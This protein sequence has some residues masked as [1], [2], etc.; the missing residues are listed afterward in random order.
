MQITNEECNKKYLHFLHCLTKVFFF[1]KSYDKN[2]QILKWLSLDMKLFVFTL[3]PGGAIANSWAWN[4]R[5][6]WPGEPGDRGTF[7]PSEKG[8]E[9]GKGAPAHHNRRVPLFL[10]LVTIYTLSPSMHLYANTYT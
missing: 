4:T 7:S 9:R 6:S 3:F 8:R 5:G 10:Y 2:E 1:W